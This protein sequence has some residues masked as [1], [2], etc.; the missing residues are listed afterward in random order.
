MI[1][2]IYL[3]CI[4]AFYGVWT[5]DEETTSPAI[6]YQC[7]NSQYFIFPCKCL[8]G[9]SNGVTIL[10]E[11]ANLAMLAVGISNVDLPIRNLT[12]TNCAISK[13][14]G[15][16]FRNLNVSQ[17]HATHNGIKELSDDVFSY[18]NESL[19]VLDLH[20]NQLEWVPTAAIHK[21][22]NLKVINLSKNQIQIVTANTFS[23]LPLLEEIFLN[24]NNIIKME[25]GSLNGL[26]R[27]ERLH[28][29]H[30]NI[31]NIEKKLF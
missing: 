2:L 10:C 31:F 14:F 24:D 25:P 11:K 18:L 29:H 13:L 17:L 19:Q 16:L 23:S 6:I 8:S 7:P 4:N 22:R 12:I 9:K 1:L 15:D 5:E 20:G 27:L 30:N 26:R 28:L 3:I 21:L